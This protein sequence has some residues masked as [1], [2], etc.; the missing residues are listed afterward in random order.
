MT[1]PKDAEEQ[2]NTKDTIAMGTMSRIWCTCRASTRT[3]RKKA[4]TAEFKPPLKEH[5]NMPGDD[6]VVVQV[7]PEEDGQVRVPAQRLVLTILMEKQDGDLM[8]IMPV[9]QKGDV[10]GTSPS[11]AITGPARAPRGP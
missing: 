10:Y 7:E 5:L 3:M 1:L 11:N 6:N 9:D 2:N 4:R 8:L